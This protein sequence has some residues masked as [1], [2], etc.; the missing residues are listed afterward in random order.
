M[1]KPS[2]TCSKKYSYVLILAFLP[3][4]PVLAEQDRTPAQAKADFQISYSAALDA[5]AK[6][7]WSGAEV[8]LRSALKKLGANPHPEKAKAQAILLT[9]Q[10]ANARRR[11]LET[12][13]KTAQ[14]MLRQ[15]QWAEAIAGLS[16][17]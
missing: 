2:L 12:T 17:A 10:R 7:D 13:L 9:A 6:K 4:L 11:E 15:E 14:E 3:A 5:I 16:D 1:S 8:L